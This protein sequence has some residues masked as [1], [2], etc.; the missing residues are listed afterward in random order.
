MRRLLPGVRCFG[1]FGGSAGVIGIV[2]SVCV[3]RLVHE[4]DEGIYVDRAAIRSQKEGRWRML[5]SRRT[6]RKEHWH[7]RARRRSSSLN[8]WRF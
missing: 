7:S 3:D 4:P 8:T 2:G 1:R 5:M 6:Q